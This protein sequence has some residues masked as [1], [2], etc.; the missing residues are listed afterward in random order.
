M[1]NVYVTNIEYT[2]LQALLDALQALSFDETDKLYILGGIFEQDSAQDT[3]DILDFIIEK[4]NI[5]VIVGAIEHLYIV[6]SM[7]T[8]VC[9]GTGAT[10]SIRGIL[11]H[12][13]NQLL[14]LGDIFVQ[15]SQILRENGAYMKYLTKCPYYEKLYTSGY[16]YV[17]CYGSLE[18][19]DP[20]EE[21]TIENIIRQNEKIVKCLPDYAMHYSV[22]VK[23]G[24]IM[25][26]QKGTNPENDKGAFLPVIL[27]TAAEHTAVRMQ[28]KELKPMPVLDTGS[29]INIR[30]GGK[31]ERVLHDMQSQFTIISLKEGTITRG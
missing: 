27:V 5:K 3:K 12:Y 26:I 25:Q 8:S 23:N 28:K 30:T 1:Q 4:S 9:S 29:V 10:E 24:E 22:N 19:K 31:K 20:T 11:Q 14:G 13:R 16:E 18:T 2:K 6:N 21:I 17:L 7:L 15:M